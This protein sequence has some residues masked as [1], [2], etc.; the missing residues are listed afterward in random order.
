M[1]GATSKVTIGEKTSVCLFVTPLNM[2]TPDAQYLQYSATPSADKFSKLTIAGSWTSNDKSFD[3]MTSITYTPLM[4]NPTVPVWDV[5]VHVQSMDKASTVKGFRRSM[6]GG[7]YTMPYF[8]AI[9]TVDTG[10]VTGITWDDGCLFCSNT[11]DS[12]T[13]NSFDVMGEKDKGKNEQGKDCYIPDS[14]CINDSGEVSEVC[15]LAVY[16]V[17]AG[18]DSKGVYFQSSRLRFSQ[19]RGYQLQQY[20]DDVQG[21]YTYQGYS[22]NV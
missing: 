5:G 2:T 4:S 12:C 9:V 3:N 21:K 8:T 1:T 10:D 19:F 6:S 22:V 11:H 14:E 16:V 20:R 7:N 17:W 13:D 18:T 15:P